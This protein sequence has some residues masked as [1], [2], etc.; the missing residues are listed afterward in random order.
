MLVDSFD[1]AAFES[2]HH[3]TI[4]KDQDEY[5]TASRGFL[6]FKGC[7]PGEVILLGAEVEFCVP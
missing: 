7:R 2:M 6:A 3:G 4:E 1:D 5:V